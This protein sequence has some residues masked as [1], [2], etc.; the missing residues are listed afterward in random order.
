MSTGSLS[1]RRRWPG[2][3][4]D[5]DD[6]ERPAGGEGADGVDEHFGLRA[7]DEHPRVHAQGDA[8]EL[9]VAAQVRDRLARGPAGHECV[10]PVSGIGRELGIRVRDEHFLPH[11]ADVREQ[12][13]GVEGRRRHA[14][15]AE[16]HQGADARLAASDH[17]RSIVAALFRTSGARAVSQ[18]SRR[19]GGGGSGDPRDPA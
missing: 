4:A 8:V 1:P 13:V 15:G 3:G 17:A 19:G 18:R 10:V 9:L 6:G 7:R 12:H 11:T 5:I 16:D 2:A 14:R